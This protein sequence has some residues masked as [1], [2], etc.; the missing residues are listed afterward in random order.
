MQNQQLNCTPLAAVACQ[1]TN[2]LCKQQ[3]ILAGLGKTA[4]SAGAHAEGLIVNMFENQINND[5]NVQMVC[6]H[7]EGSPGMY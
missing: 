4:A 1:T 5:R 2:M 6:M 7:A 3:E